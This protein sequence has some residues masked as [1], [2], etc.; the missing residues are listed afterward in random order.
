MPTEFE[1]EVYKTRVELASGL[2]RSAALLLKEQLTTEAM[3]R[4]ATAIDFQAQ[5][6]AELA[7]AMMENDDA[8]SA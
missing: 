7:A 6:A 1:E 2:T 5:A 4:L 8:Q 3:S